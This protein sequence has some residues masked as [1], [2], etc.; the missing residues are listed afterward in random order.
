MSLIFRCDHCKQDIISQ[1]PESL[2]QG[3]DFTVFRPY[4][5]E[6]DKAPRPEDYCRWFRYSHQEF[7]LCVDCKIKFLEF[8]GV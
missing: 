7:H 5:V 1:L 3:K 4:K 6:F 2:E 8:M